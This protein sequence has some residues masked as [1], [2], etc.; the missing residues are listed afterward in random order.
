MTESGRNGHGADAAIDIERG[1]LA[2]M[3][4]SP[5]GPSKNDRTCLRCGRNF[6]A[7]NTGRAR[8]YLCVPPEPAEA[9]RILADIGATPP[10]RPARNGNSNGKEVGSSAVALR[11]G[12]IQ[13]TH[14]NPG[15]R[16]PASRHAEPFEGTLSLPRAG[17]SW[18]SFWCR[19]AS[20]ITR[21]LPGKRALREI[22]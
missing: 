20:E 18:R 5:L 19:F 14:G 6:W 1:G 13:E 21:R 8:C 11:S 10:G 16:F 17:S 2:W 15:S 4:W 7:W 3:P 12:L 22:L 9:R